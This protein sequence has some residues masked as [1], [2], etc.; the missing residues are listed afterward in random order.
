MTA[1]ALPAPPTSALAVSAPAA[2]AALDG[3]RITL[4]RATTPEQVNRARLEAEVLKKA[5]ENAVRAGGWHLGE[6]H[7]Q[8]QLLVLEAAVTLGERALGPASEA[9]APGT[10][11]SVSALAK[12]LKIPRSTLRHYVKIARARRDMAH[13]YDAL[14]EEALDA[15]KPIPWA[16]LRALV[17][18][19]PK[20][21][22][23][24]AK[25]E[26]VKVRLEPRDLEALDEERAGQDRGAWVRDLVVDAVGYPADESAK[27]L[28]ERALVLL[29]RVDTAEARRAAERVDAALKAIDP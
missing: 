16:K 26:Q 20:P 24:D 14:V 13:A 5:L 10:T 6:I 8:A 2:E 15:G 29:R 11:P 23:A 28:L 17:R 25:T 21:R 7:R 1:V 4:E 9:V 18:G 27:R 22:K 12:L 19:E 3:A